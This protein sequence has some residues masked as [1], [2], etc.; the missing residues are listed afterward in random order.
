MGLFFDVGEVG[1]ELAG[2]KQVIV[3]NFAVVLQVVQVALS[4]YTDWS[5][6]CFFY[7]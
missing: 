6:V 2:S 7:D 5:G 3:E 4:P 1:V